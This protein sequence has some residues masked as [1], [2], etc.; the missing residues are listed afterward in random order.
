MIPNYD[1]EIT[2][3]SWM[4]SLDYF[5][6]FYTYNGRNYH[7]LYSEFTFDRVSGSMPVTDDGIYYGKFDDGRVYQLWKLVD[8]EFMQIV[9][10]FTQCITP[11]EIDDYKE[12][13]NLKRY[14]YDDSVDIVEPIEPCD[15]VYER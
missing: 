14:Y 11:D 13:F 3:V 4:D 7:L 2:S 8:G 6:I 12:L 15:C 9:F 1:V 5:G 10:D